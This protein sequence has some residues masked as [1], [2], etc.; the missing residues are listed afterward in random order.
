MTRL[1]IA[2]M[3]SLFGAAATAANFSTTIGEETGRKYIVISGAIDGTEAQQLS[4]YKLLNPDH[5]WVALNSP[6]GLAN[7]GYALGNTI[8]QL[9]LNTYVGYGAICLSACYTAFLGGTEYDIDGVLGAHHAWVPEEDLG[10][11]PNINELLSFGQSLGAYDTWYHMAHGFNFGL[12]YGI[13]NYTSPNDF[14]IFTDVADLMQF[15]SRNEGPDINNYLATDP[16]TYQWIGEN[17]ANGSELPQLALKNARRDHPEW[18]L[19][20]TVH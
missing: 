13:S 14:L 12:A 3:L 7:G 17:I 1:L 9:G 15:F 6:G 4:M 2:V 8:S 20:P 5:N 18:F 10:E 16:V 19:D 11:D